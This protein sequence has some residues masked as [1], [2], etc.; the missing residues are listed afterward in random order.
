MLIRLQW[1]RREMVD[2]ATQPTTR[3][4][5][6][7]GRDY[8]NSP[9][10]F[11]KLDELHARLADTAPIELVIHGGATGVDTIA[12]AWAWH[13]LIPVLAFPVSTEEWGYLGR[14]AGPLRNKHMLAKGKPN[15]VVAFPG[16]PGT[17][18]MIKQAENAGVKV[19]K[20]C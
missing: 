2:A 1:W 12:Q 20:I 11:L 14:A 5:V 17:T 15:L 6:C 13:N 18:N 7:G 10:V 16:G 8:R 3:L 19:E 9:H 4:L